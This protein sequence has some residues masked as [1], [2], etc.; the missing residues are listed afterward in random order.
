[1]ALFNQKPAPS[2][3]SAVPTGQLP[4]NQKQFEFP[5]NLNMVIWRV[6]FS[7][8]F[9]FAYRFPSMKILMKK[10]CKY[11]KLAH[12]YYSISFKSWYAHTGVFP[13]FLSKFLKERNL[14]E[15]KKYL[16]AQIWLKFS[17]NFITKSTMKNSFFTI[18]AFKPSFL[19][20]LKINT[21]LVKR[22]KECFY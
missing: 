22:S 20:F 17:N 8:R 15:K 9:I 1:M 6:F 7:S 18:S 4:V 10:S 16:L 19:F 21:Y 13:T 12:Y 14:F 5:A 3:Q 11:T 2:A